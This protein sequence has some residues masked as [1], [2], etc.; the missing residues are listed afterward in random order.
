MEKILIYGGSSLLSIELIKILYEKTK[1]FIIFCR[2]KDI[3]L[4]KIAE[5]KF[6]I[7]K[8]E[9]HEVDLEDLEKNFDIVESIDNL[10]GIYWIAGYNGNS[11]VEIE[12]EKSCK[13]N[14]K[15]NFLHPILIIN[16]LINKIITERSPFIAVVTSVAGLRGR[17]KNMFYGS[18]KAAMIA[19]LSGLRQK[20]NNNVTVCTIIPGY[21]STSKF[22]INAPKFLISSPSSLARKMVE[23]VRSKKEIIYCSLIW[24]IIMFIVGIIP[25]KIFKKLKF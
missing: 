24:R 18:A 9:L 11:S 16:K 23:G 22:D 21:I 7:D 20:L 19:Y 3:F 1:F 14:I 17:S 4:K 8:F 13:K 25:E 10:R 15:V 5:L 6:S 12:N 2:N